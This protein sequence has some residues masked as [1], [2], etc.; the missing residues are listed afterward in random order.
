LKEIIPYKVEISRPPPTPPHK[1][2]KL[3]RNPV[4][5]WIFV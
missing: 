5:W 3:T 2:K 1:K 4:N